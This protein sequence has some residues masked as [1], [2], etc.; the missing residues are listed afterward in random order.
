VTN[1]DILAPM[2]VTSTSHSRPTTF[3]NSNEDIPAPTPVPSSCT[4]A[5]L[6]IT[7]QPKSSKEEI[8]YHPKLGCMRNLE[9]NV[10]NNLHYT[11]VFTTA[12]LSWTMLVS[13]LLFYKKKGGCMLHP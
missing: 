11:V 5:L 7:P 8:G 10:S 2:P 4:V 13:L 6:P 1:K 12:I 3:E 9:N